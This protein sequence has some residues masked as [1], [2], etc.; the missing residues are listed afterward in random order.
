[1][2]P[3]RRRKSLESFHFIKGAVCEYVYVSGKI[4]FDSLDGMKVDN[5]RTE[6]SVKGLLRVREGSSDVD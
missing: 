1:M 5:S 3:E 2:L 6:M 4:T